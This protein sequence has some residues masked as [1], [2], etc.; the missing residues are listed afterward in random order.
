MIYISAGLFN[1]CIVEEEQ[2]QQFGLS[3]GEIAHSKYSDPDE[4]ALSIRVAHREAT[5]VPFSSC[6]FPSSHHMP[7]LM[8]A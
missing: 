1:R 7:M 5:A 2:Q 4:P 3:D 8:S 6:V